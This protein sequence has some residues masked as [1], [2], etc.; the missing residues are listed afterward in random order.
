MRGVAQSGSSLSGPRT[1]ESSSSWEP[2]PPSYLDHCRCVAIRHHRVAVVVVA[3]VVVVFIIASS[4]WLPLCRGGGGGRRL[5]LVVVMGTQGSHWP[6][7]RRQWLR[8][9]CGVAASVVVRRWWVLAPG[10]RCEPAINV[11]TMWA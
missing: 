8:C 9:P 6:L 3:P 7:R 10:E 5:R 4:R 11:S 1:T 2:A